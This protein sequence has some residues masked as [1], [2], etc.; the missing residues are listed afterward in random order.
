MPLRRAQAQTGGDGIDV[1]I[2]KI[3]DVTLSIGCLPGLHPSD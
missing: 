2:H 3:F 1:T